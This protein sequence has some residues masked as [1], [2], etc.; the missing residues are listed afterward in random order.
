MGKQRLSGVFTKFVATDVN[1]AT[2][3][4]KEILKQFDKEF[5][6]TSSRIGYLK[7]FVEILR[8]I[9]EGDIDEENADLNSI[10]NRVLDIIQKARNDK[11]ESLKKAATEI[12]QEDVILQFMMRK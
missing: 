10:I 3:I 11:D 7:D 6:P 2:V 9:A 4:L 5:L 12:S 1:S 8:V